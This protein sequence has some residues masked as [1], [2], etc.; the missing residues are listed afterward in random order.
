MKLTEHKLKQMIRKTLNESQDAKST[1]KHLLNEIDE[2]LGGVK[3][4]QRM[5]DRNGHLN[6]MSI[7]HLDDYIENINSQIKQLKNLAD[8]D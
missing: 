8:D 7:N 2:F 3:N 4:I 1:L 6:Q 5:L